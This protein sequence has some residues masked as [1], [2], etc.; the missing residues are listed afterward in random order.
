MRVGVSTRGVGTRKDRGVIRGAA[1]LLVLTLAPAAAQQ[2]PPARPPA[3]PAPPA[4]EQPAP[5]WL[6]GPAG[7]IAPPQTGFDL[8]ATPRPPDCARR[9][10]TFRSDLA[11][12]LCEDQANRFV[13][14]VFA[15]RACLEG[16]IGRAVRSANET[17][18]QLR[19][20]RSS[21]ADCP[22]R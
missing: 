3:A 13:A 9:D 11:R 8:C 6:G 14:Q 21:L 18:A 7:P 1:L 19:C 10:E 20:R 12:K 4:A 16:E 2:R 15:Y 5:V 17:A 22:P